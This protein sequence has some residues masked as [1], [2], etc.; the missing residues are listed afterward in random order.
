MIHTS[1]IITAVS[2]FPGNETDINLLIESDTIRAIM[3]T[4]KHFNLV[5]GTDFVQTSISDI[6]SH[7]DYGL[8]VDNNN[9]IVGSLHNIALVKTRQPVELNKFIKIIKIPTKRSN[10][11]ACK[12]ATTVGTGII[13]STYHASENLLYTNP[14][15]YQGQPNISYWLYDPTKFYT[16][17]KW[18]KGSPGLSF[19]GPFVCY[20]GR[21]PVLYGI[22]VDDHD[23]NS[24][25]KDIDVISKYESVQDHTKFIKEHVKFESTKSVGN[26]IKAGFYQIFCLLLVSFLI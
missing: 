22:R 15:L 9:K 17:N 14:K 12:N 21:T 8:C 10:M 2:Y 13:E 25:K 23:N 18:L 7:P 24:T 1:W 3:G 19:G 11:K 26:F 5:K 6:I 20:H 16:V 4:N